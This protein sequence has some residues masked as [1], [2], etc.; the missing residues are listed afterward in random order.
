MSACS[1]RT[2][3]TAPKVPIRVNGV[4][5]SRAVISREVQNHP[6]P[7]PVAAWRAA[8]L[9]LVLR[10][11]LAQE[12]RRLGIRAEPATDAEGRRETEEEAG[13][14]ALVER[15][16]VVPEPTEEECRR[17][18]ERNR[19]RFRAPDLV[20]ASHIL[21]AA[22]KDD[23]TGYELARLNARTVV[24]MLKADPDTFEELA[25][26]HSACPSAELGG[27]LGQVTT[28]QTT[29]EFEAALLGM[30]PGE[31]SSEPVET[32]YGFHV[33]RLGRRIDGCTLPFEA[34]R[35]RIAEYLSEAV[36]RRAQAQ[37]V[38]R[39]LAQARIEGIEIPA[40]G[41]LNVH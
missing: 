21:F 18:Y 31:T 38:A 11:A 1:I 15:E 24:A 10:E 29:P 30:R 6:A 34:V 23:A 35:Q 22:R 9:A 26:V 8:A 39:L 5:I 20:E 16:A 2:V 40:P 4:T 17:Y 32:R 7:T 19:A 41:A 28:G 3:P 14:R 27:S 36:R 37:Y 25:R 33:I 13:M 12:A